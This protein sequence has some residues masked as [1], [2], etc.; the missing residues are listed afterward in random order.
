MAG[1]PGTS[2]RLPAKAEEEI[3]KAKMATAKII[4]RKNIIFSFSADA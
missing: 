1:L 3:K 2:L 4:L